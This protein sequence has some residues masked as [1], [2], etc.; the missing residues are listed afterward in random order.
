MARIKTKSLKQV[1]FAC[2]AIERKIIAK[3]A[4]RA[5]RAAQTFELRGLWFAR[6]STLDWD[7]DFV[8]THR[9]GTPLDLEKLLGFDDA[10]FAHDA[11][12][13]ARHL[14]RTTGELRNFFV[15]RCA[16]PEAVPGT[17]AA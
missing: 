8:A 9:N 1:D 16:R 17:E 4:Q 5:R 12:G 11:F 6:R 3:I 7:M 15:P 10:N 13:I 2:T 14:D